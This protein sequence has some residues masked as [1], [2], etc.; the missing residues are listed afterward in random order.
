MLSLGSANFRDY[1]LTFHCD[2][3][4]RHSHVKVD[5]QMVTHTTM[6]CFH[7]ARWT[8]TLVGAEAS[9][10]P[11]PGL[12]H[13]VPILGHPGLP[14]T[15]PL[16]GPSRTLLQCLWCTDGLFPILLPSQYNCPYFLLN[17]YLGCSLWCLYKH[18][19]LWS[20]SLSMITF[21]FL[22]SFLLLLQWMPDFL[23]HFFAH[24]NTI[25]YLP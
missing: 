15:W 18:C 4:P 3:T 20:Q 21:F 13:P 14:R 5:I 17:S 11:H 7:I 24:L 19:S 10:M 8:S 25:K 12:P 6:S 22:Y 9:S 23:I 2:F 16:R 1:A